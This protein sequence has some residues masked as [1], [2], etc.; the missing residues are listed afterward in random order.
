MNV[1]YDAEA[2]TFERAI[3]V[4]LIG[5]SDL[6]PAS[7]FVSW[8]NVCDAI[9]KVQGSSNPV[10]IMTWLEDV[11]AS[12]KIDGTYKSNARDPVQL[13][14]KKLEATIL[15][16][17]KVTKKAAA[18]RGCYLT[19]SNDNDVV[20]LSSQAPQAST[21]LIRSYV[22]APKCS[23][24][25]FG[26]VR[27]TMDHFCTPC[28]QFGDYKVTD[29]PKL[30][31]V[32]DAVY[33]KFNE[34]MAMPDTIEAYA[35]CMDLI[36]GLKPIEVSI[37]YA[38]KMLKSIATNDDYGVAM[39]KIGNETDIALRLSK[40]SYMI[41]NHRDDCL[42]LSEDLTHAHVKFLML[43]NEVWKQFDNAKI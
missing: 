17:V 6:L 34:W 27:D 2:I 25:L 15:Q 26:D 18:L 38:L 37:A 11:V 31:T 42:D 22:V 4:Q 30:L 32:L 3:L 9:K 43:R 28:T 24:T 35:A 14:I 40:A 7:T 36:N 39:D 23:G 21:G 33:N 20:V 13:V 1:T 8:T 10:W 16:P 29:L 12:I 19:R 41:L 5:L